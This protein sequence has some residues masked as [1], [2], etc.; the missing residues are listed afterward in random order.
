MTAVTISQQ[1]LL[2]E[3]KGLHMQDNANTTNGISNNSSSNGTEKRA[4]TATPYKDD[5][6]DDDYHDTTAAPTDINAHLE[7]PYCRML[8]ETEHNWCRAVS[9]G[10]GIT[11]LS[12]LFKRVLDPQVLQQAAI[13]VQLQHPRLRSQLLWI[14]RRPAFKVSD[15]PYVKVEVI[16]ATSPPPPS[17]EEEAEAEAKNEVK[18]EDID[19]DGQEQWSTAELQDSEDHKWM[20]HL[21]TELNTNMWPEL[22]HC[23]EPI[24]MFVVRLYLLP[25]DR[26]LVVLRLHTA[27]CDRVAAATVLVD[28]LKAL[29]DVTV[30]VEDVGSSAVQE[31]PSQ[32]SNLGRQCSS[33]STT[34]THNF[35][36]VE[37]S[38]PP[39][40]ANKP[41][42][43][44]GIDIL[45]Y[46]LGT[47]R[48]ALLPFDEPNSPRSSKFF[49]CIL[50]V[51]HTKQLVEACE[52]RGTSVYGVLCAAG[53]KAAAAIKLLG[54]RSEHFAVVTLVNCR[55]LLQP[56]LSESTVGFYHSALMNTHHI[57][58]ETDF[59]DLVKRCSGSIDDAM[60]NRKHFTDMGDLNYLMFQAIQHPGVT[61]SC[62]MRTSLLVLFRDPV[63]GEMQ[64]LTET[65]GIEHY[66][67]CSS[68]HGVGP[69][70][71]IFDSVRNGALHFTGMYPN[72]LYSRA[73]M[74]TYL[75]LMV[76][77]IVQSLET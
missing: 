11:V 57:N 67:G 63:L 4:L 43:A 34:E 47:R 59:W 60:R 64:D 54:R 49:H 40:K 2:P 14:E 77:I 16:D 51:D 5:D 52:K 17:P 27:V 6:G 33:D 26:S 29:R 18:N 35:I 70:L 53:M 73:Q 3:M 36:S 56:R 66:V 65:L 21:E 62:S 44:H 31:I 50:S 41:F 58:E 1:P 68:I 71:A 39:G 48:H 76:D 8:G 10:T 32:A 12:M 45:G 55:Q 19:A 7:G 9:S 15:D 28:L 20:A 37:E 30:G 24:D 38:I 75:R 72:P 69:T 25:E 13:S 22:Q 42:W 74:L 61:P 46:S 23:L